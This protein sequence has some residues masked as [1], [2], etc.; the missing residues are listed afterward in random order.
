MIFAIIHRFSSGVTSFSFNFDRP[1]SSLEYI[2]CC[3]LPKLQHLELEGILTEPLHDFIHRHNV[4]ITSLVLCN[5]A[6]GLHGGRLLGP[7]PG[8]THYQGPSDYLPLIAP[9]SVLL[10]VILDIDQEYNEMDLYRSLGSLSQTETPLSKACLRSERWNSDC[11]GILAQHASELCELTYQHWCI[12]DY[13]GC[14][15]DSQVKNSQKK[16]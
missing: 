16:F 8:L 15:E 7:F 3:T 11:L 6:G 10:S 13:E 1:T 2:R 12:A 9:G 5:I 14:D 4:T